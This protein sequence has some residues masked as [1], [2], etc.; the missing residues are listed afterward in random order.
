MLPESTTTMGEGE[1]VATERPFQSMKA[2]ERTRAKLRTWVRA[3]RGWRVENIFVF[4]F[5]WVF[6]G[7]VLVWG[8][9]CLEG[10]EGVEE[11][12]KGEEG[13]ECDIRGLRW[14]GKCRCRGLVSHGRAIGVIVGSTFAAVFKVFGDVAGALPCIR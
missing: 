9:G 5:F 2:V 11:G 6:L 1:S 7:L 12:E 4:N 8:S 14:I 10:E 3:R 13:E